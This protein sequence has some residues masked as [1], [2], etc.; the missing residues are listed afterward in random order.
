MEFIRR[1]YEN[2]KLTIPKEVRDLAGIQP[3]DYVKL[4]V[5]S[6]IPSGKLPPANGDGH[7][8]GTEAKDA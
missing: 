4:V 1:I 5:V 3:G 8:N 7:G 2:G 6:V